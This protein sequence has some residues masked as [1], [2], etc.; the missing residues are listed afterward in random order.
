MQIPANRG[1]WVER[2]PGAV[3]LTDPE[4]IIVHM[5]DAAAVVFAK[6]GGRALVG[7]SVLDCHPEPSRA[8]LA[9]LLSDRATNVYS[10]EKNGRRR[11]IYQT[12]W[13]DGER[14]GGLMELSLP[15]P[16]EM[17]HFVRGGSAIG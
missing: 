11:I 1:A 6:D 7:R 16:A 9:T 2:F 4:G 5:N 13:Y 14:Y 8:K 3:M 12:P 10:I 15:L 17:P